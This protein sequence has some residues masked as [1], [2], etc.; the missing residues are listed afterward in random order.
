MGLVLSMLTWAAPAASIAESVVS[1]VRAE[2]RK[3]VAPLAH[4]QSSALLLRFVALDDLD[5]ERVWMRRASRAMARLLF[6]R[7]NSSLWDAM[8]L[9]IVTVPIHDVLHMY[10]QMMRAMNLHYVHDV[11]WERATTTGTQ[12]FVYGR[13][14]LSILDSWVEESATIRALN[15]DGR[16]R[17][18]RDARRTAPGLAVGLRLAPPA[19]GRVPVLDAHRRWF[20]STVRVRHRDIGLGSLPS[21][22]KDGFR[23]HVDAG[24]AHG[25]RATSELCSACLCGGDTPSGPHLL[26]ACPHPTINHVTRGV[27]TP[28][29]RAQERLLLPTIAQYPYIAPEGMDER[30]RLAL[31]ELLSDGVGPVNDE[32]V[33]ATDGSIVDGVATSAWATDSGQAAAP[34][35]SP[36]G[37]I[38]SAEAFAVLGAVGCLRHDLREHRHRRVVIFSDCRS[39]LAVLRDRPLCKEWWRI[40]SRF[41]EDVDA[42]RRRHV[43]LMLEWIPSHDKNPDWTPDAEVDRGRARRLNRAAD[44]AARRLAHDLSQASGARAWADSRARAIKWAASALQHA[45]HVEDVYA[46]HVDRLRAD[47]VRHGMGDAPPG[48]PA[49]A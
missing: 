34:T 6:L 36:D 5:V 44:E 38:F 29:D 13:D 28:T 46:G 33:V 24:L 43:D 22:W 11:G 41:R 27:L 35:P 48:Q 16:V 37:T 39:V 32:I 47:A 17:K 8:P 25:E 7:H 49:G 26:W 10:V 20:R 19:V 42:L 45:L 1:A 15:I 21:Y 23:E 2:V 12:R 4:R 18:N 3:C 9:S 40:Q 14:A 30:T 31:R